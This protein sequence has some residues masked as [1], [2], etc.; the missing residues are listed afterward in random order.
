MTL[1]E[2]VPNF[3][4]GRDKSKV[5]QIKSAISAI[6]TVRILDVEMDSNHNRSVIT[7]VCD[8]G[9]AVEAA[10]AGIKKAAE[11]IDMDKHTGEHPRFGAADVIPFVPL[12]DTKMSRCVQLARELGKRVGDEL[13]IPVFLYAEAATRP[14]RADLAAIRNKSFQYEQLKGAIKEEKWKPDF[15]PSEVGK[16]GASIIG[17]RDFLIAYNVNLNISDVEIGKKIASALRARDGG[18]TFVKALAFYLKDRNIV[19][20]SM[21]LTNFRKTPIYRAYELVK[22]EA[23][24]Y[25]AYP[26]ES[27]IVGL[28]PE[29]ALID[30]AKF[31]LQ[32]NGFDEHNLIE[33]KINE[34]VSE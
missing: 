28:V 13:N 29:Q 12:D 32:L 10:F 9:K 20:I 23:S 3:S 5:D 15:G 14:E 8:D 21:N 1:I 16:A 2:C 4:E 30:A 19:Q 11:L 34:N 33:R 26:I 7:F 18:L 22:L 25:G 17:A 31:Y 6:P 24:R 27:E